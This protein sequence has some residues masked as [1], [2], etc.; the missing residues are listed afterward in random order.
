LRL[1]FAGVRAGALVVVLAAAWPAVASAGA[2][3]Y[4]YAGLVGTKGP[5]GISGTLTAR[6]P[7][8][9]QAGHVAAWVGVGGPNE[10]P[11][12]TAEWLQVGMNSARGSVD[13]H[14]YF[15]YSRPG[16][17]V[18][19][20]QVA[21]NV[22]VGQS[23]RVAV[24]KTAKG[25]DLWRVWVDGKPVSD[26]I[27]LP[28]SEGRLTPVATAENSDGGSPGVVN[29]F[30]YSV[31]GVRVATRAGGVWRPFTGAQLRQ[32]DGVQVIQSAPASFV[33]GSAVVGRSPR[34]RDVLRG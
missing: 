3:G 10:A 23:V 32:D 5:L 12:G 4:C 33:A 20:V 1:G 19:Y 27:L 2:T 29:T 13:N 9:V 22:P 34:A 30:S 31:A 24:L 16:I 14:L 15:E 11:D 8:V 25:R 7:A 6:A 28:G 18:K 17:P 26:P 21:A